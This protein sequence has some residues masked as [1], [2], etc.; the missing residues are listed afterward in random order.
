MGSG[1]KTGRRPQEYPGPERRRSS[2][3]RA[4]T[5]LDFDARGNPILDV[6]VDTPRRR[7]DDDTLDAIECLDIERFSLQEQA[8]ESKGGYDPY[9][10]GVPHTHKR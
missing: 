10:S 3:T 9:D 4:H 2:R 7:E 6:R 1:H 5:K 8:A